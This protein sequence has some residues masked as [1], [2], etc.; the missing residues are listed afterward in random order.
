MTTLEVAQSL[1]ALLRQSRNVE[2]YNTLYAAETECVEADPK[3]SRTGLPRLTADMQAFADAHEF[4]YTRIEGPM[5]VGETFAV[6]LSF[7]ATPRS[8]AASF[9]VHEIGVYTVRNGKI[10]REQ[11]F[12]DVA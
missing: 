9:D 6:A 7:R 4:H 1:I 5:V 11:F 8:G 2:A 10:I 3:R 12:Y